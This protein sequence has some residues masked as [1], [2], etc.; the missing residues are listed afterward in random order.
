MTAAELRTRGAR[1]PGALDE[2]DPEAIRA[3]LR[4]L[5]PRQA[6]RVC[7]AAAAQGGRLRIGG[8]DLA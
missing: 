1:L 6:L 2:A 5:T 7:H 3:V 8:G 4:E